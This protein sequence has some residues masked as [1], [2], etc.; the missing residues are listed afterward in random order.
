MEPECNF[1]LKN[2][3]RP[4]IFS[5]GK[6]GTEIIARITGA[7][8]DKTSLEILFSDKKTSAFQPEDIS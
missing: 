5:P 4:W 6:R 1:C 7:G 8:Q 3:I 2:P